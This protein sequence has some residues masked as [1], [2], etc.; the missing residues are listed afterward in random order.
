[1]LKRALFLD[2][3]GIINEDK[4]YVHSIDEFKFISDIFELVRLAKSNGYIVIIVTNQA[5]IGR[6]YYTESDFDILN[7][8]MLSEFA[9]QNAPVDG[10]YYSP[11]HPTHGKGRYLLD[12]DLRKP[13][14]GML[15]KAAVDFDI[16]LEN[17][18]I[19]GDNLSDVFAGKNAGIKKRILVGSGLCNNQDYILVPSVAGALALLEILL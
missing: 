1:M 13:K 18:I 4:G 2:R 5:G 16:D 3:D 12:S 19:I 10:V 14:P 17:S 9:K 11:Y 15:L 8:W 6:G 7:N